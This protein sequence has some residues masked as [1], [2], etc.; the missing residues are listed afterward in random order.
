MPLGEIATIRFGVKS[1]CDA[2]FMPR[3]VSADFLEKYSKL[4]WNEAPLMTHCKRAEVESGN[5]K[6]IEA[7]DGTVHPVESEYLK[8][9]VHS[10][11][12]VS[13][14]LISK[15]IWTIVLMVSKPKGE[16]KGTYV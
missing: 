3:D 16:L 8:P 10:L 13:R 15:Q 7:G 1:G 14:P 12:N 4:D 5:V 6:L 11:M 9:E 2:F